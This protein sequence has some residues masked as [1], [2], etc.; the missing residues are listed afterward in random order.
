MEDTD[1][2]DA[3]G[4]KKKRSSTPPP[5]STKAPAAESSAVAPVKIDMAATT[6]PA[7][8]ISTKQKALYIG[9]GVAIGGLAIWGILKLRK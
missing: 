7:T 8:T 4:P 1:F 6:C 2:Y 5:P 9:I 3:T